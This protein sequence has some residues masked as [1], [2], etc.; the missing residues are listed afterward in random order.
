MAYLNNAETGT[1]YLNRLQVSIQVCSDILV[2]FPD[3]LSIFNKYF[4]ELDL[5]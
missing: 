4:L 3:L 2:L 1:E 5:P